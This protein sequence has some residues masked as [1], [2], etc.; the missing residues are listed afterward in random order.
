MALKT[1]QYILKHTARLCDH[2]LHLSFVTA[3]A[4]PVVFIPGQFVTFQIAGTE[5]T[6]H[7][8]YSIANPPDGHHLEI[9]CAC[10]PGGVA[11]EL[12]LNLKP[13]DC[14]EA[15]GPHGLLI[16]KDEQ[17]KRI[18]FVATGTGVTPYRSMMHQIAMRLKTD[19]D[20]EMIVVQGA[21][22][23]AELLF[24]E[25]FLSLSRAHANFK[26]YACYSRAE[27]T[28]ESFE[29][30]GYV[31]DLLKTLSPKPDSDLLYLCGNPNMIDDNFAL[32][33]ELGFDRKNI[34][35]EKYSFAHYDPNC[36]VI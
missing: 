12:F 30:L 9:T 6:L 25:D 29:R 13:G 22:T 28:A 5:K 23:P 15:S 7:R 32:L 35:R 3:D 4:L 31:Q 27:N 24:A 14:L 34:R 19:P 2:I 33:T 10:V 36:S 18:I 11:S 16:L 21:R 17:P 26:F 20:L 8:S 1:R